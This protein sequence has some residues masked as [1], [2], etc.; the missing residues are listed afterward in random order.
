MIAHSC[1]I[2]FIKS[3]H[4]SKVNSVS[5]F[6]FKVLYSIRMGRGGDNKLCW[7]SSKWLS[8]E[9]IFFYKVLLP[10]VDFFPWK[11]I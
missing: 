5:F 9:V 11:S 7:I 6:S 1:D 2:N 4:D 8:F 10:N 3:V